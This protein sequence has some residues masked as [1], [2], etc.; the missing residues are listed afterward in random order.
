L[1]TGKRYFISALWKEGGGGDNCAVGWTGPSSPGPGS[2]ITV[3]P[4]R[5]LQPFEWLWAYSPY[6]KVDSSDV[7][8][9]SVA[10]AWKPG[11]YSV[12]HAVYLGTA[13]D[14]VLNATSSSH[15]NVQYTPCGPNNLTVGPL[16]TATVYYWRVDEVNNLHLDKLWK[17]EVWDFRTVGGAGGLLGAY[18]H[19]SGED[20]PVNPWMTLVLTRIDPTVNFGWGDP[21]SPD[22]LVNVDDFA[23]RWAGN[24]EVPK[25]GNYMFWTTTDDG[26]RLWV[27]G[28]LLIDQWILQ[29]DTEYNSVSVALTA[30]KLYEIQF[31]QFENGGGA[32]ARLAWSGPVTPKQII[33]AMWLWPPMKASA[34]N[35]SDGA[36]DAAPVPTLSWTKG[37]KAARHNVYFGTSFNDVNNAA[38]PNVL[39]GRGQQDPT[40]YNPGTL[41]MGGTYYW[42]IDE[43]NGVYLWPGDVW[44]FTVTDHIL[45][46][47]FEDYNNISPHIIWENWIDG[48]GPTGPPS[49]NGTG[50]IV[51]YFDVNF[52]EVVLRHGGS[53]SMPMDYNNTIPPYYSEADHSFGTPQ[54][55]TAYGLKVLSLWFRGWPASP[56]GSFTQSGGT[57]TMTSNGADIWDLRYRNQGSSYHDEFHYAYQQVT[58]STV[59]MVAKVESITQTDVWAKAGVMIRDSLDGGSPHA[60]MCITP[61]SGAAFQDRINAGAVSDNNAVAG[62]TAPEYVKIELDSSGI[63]KGWYSPDGVTWTPVGTGLGLPLSISLTPPFY[64]G[65]AVTSHN[66]N[67]ICMA[68][69]SNVSVTGGSGAWSNQD[70]GIKTNTRQ[71][72]YVTLQDTGNATARVTHPDPCAIQSSTWKEWNI[73]LSSFSGV[74]LMA[75]KKMTIG[76][77]NRASPALDGTGTIYVDD[78][79]LYVPRC[80]PLLRKPAA[81]LDADCVVDYPDLGI[82]ADNWL[83]K[84]YNVTPSD[85]GTTG[86]T[87]RYQFEG[88]LQDSAGSHHGDP[89]GSSPIYV[90]GKVGQA[91]SLDGSDDYIHVGPVGIDSNDARTIAGW[92]KAVTT[93]IPD[94]A[95][96]FGFTGTGTDLTNRSF[97]ID[98]R[99][100]QMYY[101]IHVYGWEQNVAALDL[102]WHHLAATYDKT[103]MTIRWYAEGNFVGSAVRNLNTNDNVQMGKRGD[104]TSRFPGLLDEVRIYNRAL[105]QGEVAWLAGKT[106]AFT[107]PLYVMLNPQDPAIDLNSDGAINLKDYAVYAD[108]WLDE[109]L[110]P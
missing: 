72:L 86:L 17:G 19:S 68:K 5:Y 91:V 13:Y 30:G 77:G 101:C 75:I 74:N 90:A 20:I 96:V 98:R 18:Y 43:V 95:N 81:D 60:F 38:N 55:L 7:A 63:I 66:A 40:I 34:P 10:L 3:I 24:V 36:I 32:T 103:T 89:C 15:P 21:G 62:V 93:F 67:G 65:L 41:T 44:S 76:V 29:G 82:L 69:F 97:G 49:G 48:W 8:T 88:N 61:G 28:Q 45:V 31:E 9:A 109:L 73:L 79:R 26:A 105:S 84:N 110:W 2:T 39:P 100:G 99:G 108:T 85:P 94:W 16:N 54:D 83:I 107:Q 23:C 47:D 25:T 106:T 52:I 1:E 92:A 27:D 53:Q 37:V 22:P 71:P 51:G 78:I 6:P 33:P 87:A 4:G 50:S 14:D 70:I 35:P 59:T 57:Y 58:G 46:D 12:S 11:D 64:V 104:M 80:M 56:V 102:D 42:R